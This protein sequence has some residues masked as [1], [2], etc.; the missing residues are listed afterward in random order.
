M[1]RKTAASMK[2]AAKAATAVAEKAAKAK[3]KKA[4]SPDASDIDE[5]SPRAKKQNRRPPTDAGAA[6]SGPFRGHYFF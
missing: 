2:M 6:P 5:L 3:M 1:P 4:R